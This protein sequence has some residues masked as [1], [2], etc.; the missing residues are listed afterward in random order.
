MSKYE[1]LKVN[2]KKSQLQIL[3]IKKELFTELI[4]YNKYNS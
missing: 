2:M 1:F 4:N 3:K